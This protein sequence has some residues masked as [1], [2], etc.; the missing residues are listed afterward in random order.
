MI[1]YW[2]EINEYIPDPTN[3]WEEKKVYLVEQRVNWKP[4]YVLIPVT[5][6]DQVTTSGKVESKEKRYNWNMT[7]LQKLLVKNLSSKKI[8][9]PIAA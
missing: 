1:K 2:K 8:K 9:L 5:A 4:I 7:A 3:E 6:R